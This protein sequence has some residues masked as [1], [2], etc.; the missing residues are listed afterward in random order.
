MNLN[1]F[2]AL[3]KNEGEKHFRIQLPDGSPVPLSFHVTE[4]GKVQKTFIDCGGTMRENVVCQLQIWVGE[5]VDHRIEAGKAAAILEK[6]RS[7]LPDESV[8]VEVEYEDRVIS[9]YTIEDVTMDESSVTLK[10]AHKHTQCL[11]PEL[12]VVPPKTQESNCRT[13]KSGCC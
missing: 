5:D 7:F 10:L 11:A 8:P 6:A 3:L 4:V 1:E 9:Q 13:P 12:C 2:K